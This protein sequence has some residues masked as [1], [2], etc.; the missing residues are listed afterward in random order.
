MS[1]LQFQVLVTNKFSSWRR[2]EIAWVWQ[3]C[4]LYTLSFGATNF[5]TIV[6]TTTTRSH[7]L[8]FILIVDV[9]SNNVASP[10]STDI[11]W[12]MIHEARH[13]GLK[14]QSASTY[15]ISIK[16]TRS[17]MLFAKPLPAINMQMLVWVVIA[18]ELYSNIKR[19]KGHILF[20]IRFL[21][22]VRLTFVCNP[23]P[24]LVPRN[25]WHTLISFSVHQR[26][27]SIKNFVRDV[28][29]SRLMK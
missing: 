22:V 2:Y 6:S 18:K 12:K 27:W 21:F 15:G 11:A 28:M 1:I 17:R 10:S 7:F 14:L 19:V 8:F 13:T 4:N 5:S 3:F 9:V 25:L 23:F 26:K 29:V 20:F 24:F 16:P